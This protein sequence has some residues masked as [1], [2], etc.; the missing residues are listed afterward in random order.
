MTCIESCPEFCLYR[1][2]YRNRF[3]NTWT[4]PHVTAEDTFVNSDF[5]AKSRIDYV[6]CSE[7]LTHAVNN[8]CVH[9][10]GT[11]NSWHRP[12]SLELNVDFNVMRG[13]TPE[14]QA[15]FKHDR[16]AWHKVTKQHIG[17]YQH[18]LGPV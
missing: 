5:T 9:N 3:V 8:V 18:Q 2:N 6:C 15:E 10:C 17:Q 11:N 7:N 12:I 1:P 13:N 16:V 4:L 14:C